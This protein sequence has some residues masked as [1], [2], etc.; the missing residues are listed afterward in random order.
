MNEKIKHFIQNSP[1]VRSKEEEFNGDKVFV[2]KYKNKVFYDNLWTPELQML[3]GVV[4]DKDYNIITNPFIKVFNYQER[5]TVI[6]LHHR[7]LAVQKINGFMAA[8]SFYKGKLIV[9]TSGTISSEYAD[10]ARKWLEPHEVYL[11]EI[12]TRIGSDYPSFIFEIC[13]P[14]DPHIVYENPGVYL[15]GMRVPVW[16]SP[17]NVISQFHL[18]KI[19][20]EMHVMRPYWRTYQKFSDLLEELKD[21]KHEGY[22]VYD[23]GGNKPSHYYDQPEPIYGSLKLK[24]PFY[25]TVKFLGRISDKRIE[26]LFEDPEKFKKNIDEEFY[27]I[28]D[29]IVDNKDKFLSKIKQERILYIRE[30]FLNEKS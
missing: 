5:D 25:L 10:M 2:I 29:F 9:S 22:M 11:K 21:C 18:D 1:L 12:S 7:V 26:G 13:D 14:S 6:P 15:L 24:S 23:I 4:L 16:D 28:V 19:A 20:N 30:Y 8:C 17:Q 27:K 3:R